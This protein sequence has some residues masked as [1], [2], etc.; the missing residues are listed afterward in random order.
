MILDEIDFELQAGSEATY[1]WT[2]SDLDLTG[3][4]EAKFALFSDFGKVPVLVASSLNGSGA[5][6][7]VNS[8]S[9]RID[10]ILPGSAT[11][12]W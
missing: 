9:G 7:V 10:L 12:V 8:A 4:S 2:L 5:R 1:R 3:V 11:K 6:I